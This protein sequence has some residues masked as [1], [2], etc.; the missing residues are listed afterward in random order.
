MF[1]ALCDGSS[2][3]AAA[4]I[5][6]VS[7]LTILRLL[8]DVGRLCLDYHDLTVTGLTCHRVQ[9]DQFWSFVGVKQEN[10]DAGKQGHG[11]AWTWVAM[12][13]ETKPVVSYLVGERDAACARFFAFS[14]AWVM[15]RHGACRLAVGDCP[16]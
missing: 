13:A 3:N 1:R 12:D 7:K 8:A 9:V 5:A 4:R 6:G 14:P 2:A 10:V 16:N 11:N 15:P